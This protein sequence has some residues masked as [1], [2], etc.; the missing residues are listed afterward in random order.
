M[1]H[2]IDCHRLSSQGYTH[3]SSTMQNLFTG[4]HLFEFFSSTQPYS[5]SC[6]PY[7]RKIFSSTPVL[8]S[9]LISAVVMVGPVKFKGVPPLGDGPDEGFHKAWS[10]GEIFSKFLTS[11]QDLEWTPFSPSTW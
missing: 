10:A 5:M 1:I 3:L 9:I 2:A 6:P 11:V 4:G 7:S 8:R